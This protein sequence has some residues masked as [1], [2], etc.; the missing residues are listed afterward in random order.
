MPPDDNI[1]D[2]M[3][4]RLGTLGNSVVERVT[5]N[6]AVNPLFWLCG[7]VLVSTMPGAIWGHSPVSEVC[8]GLATLAVV[9]PI[10]AY[11]IWMFRDPIKLQSEHYQLERQRI[12][13]LGD[14]RS[15][16]TPTIIEGELV[17][18]AI[19]SRRDAGQRV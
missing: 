13:L 19:V 11:F 17:D 15:R 9:S 1:S 3:R 5:T 6:S 16:T 4:A 10:V 14:E 8:L 2:G 7:V 12:E 18:N